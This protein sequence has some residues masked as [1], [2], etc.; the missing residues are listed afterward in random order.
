MNYGI[1][2]TPERADR[3]AA[4]TRMGK[5]RRKNHGHPATA[6]LIYSADQSEF[7]QAMEC[8]RRATGRFPTAADVLAVANELGYRKAPVAEATR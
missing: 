4:T 1:K 3:I 5:N 6:N 8:H 2:M 7:M